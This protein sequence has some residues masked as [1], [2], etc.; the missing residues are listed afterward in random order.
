MST[1]LRIVNGR[2]QDNEGAFT[3]FTKQGKSIV[4]Y[5]IV[6]GNVSQHLQSFNVHKKYPESDHCPLELSLYCSTPLNDCDN[7]VDGEPLF[8]FK[9]KKD[10]LHLLKYQFDNKSVTRSQMLEQMCNNEPVDSVACSWSKHFVDNIEE[11]FEKTQCK[12]SKTHKAPWIDQE[13]KELRK[14]LCADDNLYENEKH[15]LY[16]QTLQLKK[17]QYRQSVIKKL[18][19][20]ICD[21]SQFWS[22][23]NGLPSAKSSKSV[24]NDPKKCWKPN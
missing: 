24:T 23:F 5:L 16:K 10:D 4:D 13:C 8:K 7:T 9:W 21:S 20:N 15:L 14:L 2:L 22:I 19:E 11:V 3:C 18:E 6:D 1:N 17:R 12:K